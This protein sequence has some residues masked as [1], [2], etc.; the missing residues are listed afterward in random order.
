M[1]RRKIVAHGLACALCA[2]ALWLLPLCE[3]TVRGL[4]SASGRGDAPPLPPETEPIPA[5]LWWSRSVYSF[6]M[7][8]GGLNPSVVLLVLVALALPIGYCFLRSVNGSF[9]L[10]TGV[11]WDSGLLFR[12]YLHAAPITKTVLVIVTAAPVLAAVLS[13]LAWLPLPGGLS[14][15]LQAMVAGALA[16]LSL[17]RHGIAGDLEDGNYLFPSDRAARR[18]LPGS[19]ALF[20]LAV[21]LSLPAYA[22]VAPAPWLSFWTA[23][24]GVG[25]HDWTLLAAVGAAVVGVAAFCTAW[26]TT[27]LGPGIALGQ[28]RSR[29]VGPVVVLALMGGLA[30]FVW[31]AVALHRFDYSVRHAGAAPAALAA[32][33][34]PAPMDQDPPLLLVT[35]DAAAHVRIGGDDVPI[36]GKGAVTARGIEALLTRRGYRSA[37]AAPALWRLHRAAQ[38]AMDVPAAARLELLGATRVGDA[39]F[40]AMLMDRARRWPASATA[41]SAA[42]ALADERLYKCV[43]PRASLRV[44]DLLARAG[45]TARARVLYARAGVPASRVSERLERVPAVKPCRVTG[46]LT[47]AGQPLNDALVGLIEAR[48]A[49]LSPQERTVGA[50]RPAGWLR[51]LAATARVSPQGRFMFEDVTPGEYRLLIRAPSIAAGSGSQTWRVTAEWDV[52]EPFYVSGAASSMGAIRLESTSP[53]PPRAPSERARPR[54]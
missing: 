9:R 20:G 2:V 37:V 41:R 30:R 19:G 6:V 14:A 28:G 13:L 27:T 10:T 25:S 44:G 1:V 18:S 11:D 33:S 3:L 39:T 8:L 36:I 43:D 4:L 12:T 21:C 42:L 17:S 48:S 40:S 52:R 31:P 38:V 46:T 7:A 47:V 53:R 34:P 26:L 45:L 5:P 54:R 23:I 51:G 29:W 49:W 32:L 24:G 35:G 22:A 15:A 50:E 16:W